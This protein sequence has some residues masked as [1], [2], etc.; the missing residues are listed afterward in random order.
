MNKET[1]EIY[2]PDDLYEALVSRLVD[3]V[4]LLGS[5]DDLVLRL[6][7]V[8]RIWPERVQTSDSPQEFLH[9]A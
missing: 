2:V 5:R 9:A 6:G 4:P 8:A 3:V 7:E 1:A